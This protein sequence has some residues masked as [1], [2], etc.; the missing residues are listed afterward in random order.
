MPVLFST[1]MDS[2]TTGATSCPSF[3]SQ[4][5]PEMV[6][7][8]NGMWTALV[9]QPSKLYPGAEGERESKEKEQREALECQK[10]AIPD[11]TDPNQ[12]PFLLPI[13]GLSCVSIRIS[14]T[15]TRCSSRMYLTKAMAEDKVRRLKGPP[16]FTPTMRWRGKGRAV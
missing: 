15:S 13:S 1:S 11:H 16:A 2:K 14:D 9:S 7:L 8:S 3:C 10:T 12:S 6:K 5:S 4:D